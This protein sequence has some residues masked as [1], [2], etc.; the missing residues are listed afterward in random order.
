M[1]H[2]LP[3]QC[4]VL[5]G[6][7]CWVAATPASP[8]RIDP[9]TILSVS[10]THAAHCV[11]FPTAN[12]EKAFSLHPEPILRRQ[13]NT[14]G[15]SLGYTFLWLESSGR[16]AALGDIFF[17]KNHLEMRHMLNEW[18]SFSE[19]PL[20]VKGPGAKDVEKIFLDSPS[21]GLE[22]LAFPDA[23]LPASTLSVRKLQMN[24]LVRRI[25]VESTT[26]VSRKNYHLHLLTTP[27]FAYQSKGDER[28]LSGAI[29]AFCVETD[30]ECLISIE[31]R[32]VGERY[33]WQY[34][35]TA[36]TLDHLVLNLDGKQAW[37]A[38]PPVFALRSP[39]ATGFVKEV[40][41][42]LTQPPTPQPSGPP[43]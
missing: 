10:R 42:P 3:R 40:R 39:H 33:E 29:Y 4:V 20:T 27:I 18:H 15:N 31:A 41:I 24:R 37:I 16:P 35:P 11:V 32:R 36:T 38:D 23:E 12:P 13:Q 14:I 9:P 34:A 19:Q 6:L 5:L 30:P 28:F 43:K 25:A 17:F 2:H 21:P 1:R 7:V 8:D 22:W 26:H